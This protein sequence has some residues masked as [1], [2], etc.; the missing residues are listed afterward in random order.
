MTFSRL[1]ENRSMRRAVLPRR[2]ESAGVGKWGQPRSAG[3]WNGTTTG[4]HSAIL[5]R[6]ESR[7]RMAESDRGPRGL[8]VS[9]R[10][11]SLLPSTRWPRP[12]RPAYVA[13]LLLSIRRDGVGANFRE[14]RQRTDGSLTR[15]LCVGSV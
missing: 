11:G 14:S 2:G 9:R 8:V 7:P 13:A 1:Q 6:P 3:S 15:L 12:M 4:I 5:Y 10:P